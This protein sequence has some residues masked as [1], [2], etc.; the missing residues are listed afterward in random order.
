MQAICQFIQLHVL[1]EAV[2]LIQLWISL[3]LFCFQAFAK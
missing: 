2:N 3:T 1:D